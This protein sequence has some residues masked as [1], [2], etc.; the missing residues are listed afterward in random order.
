MH[1]VG[2]VHFSVRVGVAARQF[3][4]RGAAFDRTRAPV[5]DGDVDVCE[6][7]FAGAF[8]VGVDEEAE[9][10]LPPVLVDVADGYRPR[11]VGRN[12]R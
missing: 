6:V 1:V 2:D 12:R 3:L 5:E 7:P 10:L 11:A 8:Y 9:D 4:G